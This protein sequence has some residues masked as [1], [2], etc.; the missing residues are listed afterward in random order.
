[1]EQPLALEPGYDVEDLAIA[2]TGRADHE[3]RGGARGPERARLAT[4]EGEL[5]CGALELGQ[6]IA[7]E[8]LLAG[9][10]TDVGVGRRL[11]IDRN[12]SG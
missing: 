7:R 8:V 2:L 10:M 3:L 5:S 6:E 12:A 11:E 1:M 4:S 9:E